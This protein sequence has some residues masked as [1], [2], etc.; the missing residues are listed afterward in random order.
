MTLNKVTTEQK[1][2]QTKLAKKLLDIIILQFLRTQEMHGYEVIAKIRKNF[3]VYFGPSTVYPLLAALERK[4]CI[5]SNWNMDGDR[6]KKVYHLTEDGQ[7]ILITAEKALNMICQ[8][9]TPVLD[10]AAE[11]DSI[12]EQP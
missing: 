10:T 11:A 1:D 7:T 4:N 5:A 6:P 8:R 3:G 9:M 2:I 12:T